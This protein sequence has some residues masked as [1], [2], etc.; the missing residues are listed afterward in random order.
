M[1]C[2]RRAGELGAKSDNK[3]SRA[4]PS[5]TVTQHLN[6]KSRV[7]L[8]MTARAS[9][10]LCLSDTTTAMK[11]KVKADKSAGQD[12]HSSSNA[13]PKPRGGEGQDRQKAYHSLFTHSSFNSS[14]FLAWRT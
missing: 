12:H 6:K 11:S 8:V 1:G 7:G 2:S 5:A 4:V 14:F 3:A 13:T 9:Q 10:K